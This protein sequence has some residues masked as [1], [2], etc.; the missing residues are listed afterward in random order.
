MASNQFNNSPHPFLVEATNESK[1][2]K[3]SDKTGNRSLGLT[4]RHAASR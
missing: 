2:M 3:V 1:K 4:I